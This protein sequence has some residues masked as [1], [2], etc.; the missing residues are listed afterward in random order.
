MSESSFG[1]KNI[2]LTRF[3]VTFG[4]KN[5]GLTLFDGTIGAKNIGLTLFD[6]FKQ[7]DPKRYS[8]D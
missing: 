7:G 1:A 3:D 6:G 8:R 5:I 4:A 2:G